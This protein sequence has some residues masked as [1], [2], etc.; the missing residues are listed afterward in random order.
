MAMRPCMDCKKPTDRTRCRDCGRV[1]DK[2]RG[3]RQQRGYD[4][5]YDRERRD[6]QRRMDA[7]V[8]F[9]CWRCP[10]MGRAEHDVD[11]TRWQL[12]HSNTDRSVLRG[13]QCPESNLDTSISPDA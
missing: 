2:A 11:P 7:G 5:G 4:A 8:T 10:E 9:A 1:K 12:G 6:Y 13:P 3:T